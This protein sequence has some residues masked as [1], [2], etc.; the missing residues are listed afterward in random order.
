LLSS[1]PAWIDSIPHSE[2]IDRSAA[3]PLP[4][5]PAHNNRPRSLSLVDSMMG[6][7]ADPAHSGASVRQ[8]GDVTDLPQDDQ[9]D[10][11][12]VGPVL[13]IPV[14]YEDAPRLAEERA[15]WSSA[16][17][18]AQ[19]KHAP[20]ELL[21][22]LDDPDWRVRH[23]VIDRLAVRAESDPRTPHGL[24]RV[25]ATDPS[26]EVRS[27]AAMAI[28]RFPGPDA[29]TALRAACQDPHEDVRESAEFSLNQI[30]F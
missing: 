18:K 15:A 22:G 27:K 5:S 30:D 23:E 24:I 17:A 4:D 12:D 9:P 2:W 7:R 1:A 21:V 10:T 19:A 3:A 20:D 14:H 6:L 29:V 13:G 11:I 25:L 16:R 26:W 8:H 28:Q